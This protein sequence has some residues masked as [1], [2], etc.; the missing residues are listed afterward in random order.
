MSTLLPAVV[1]ECEWGAIN[2]NTGISYRGV[3]SPG[4]ECP[5]M[6]PVG[7]TPLDR[8]RVC[9]CP[10]A[11]QEAIQSRVIIVGGLVASA[12]LSYC[13]AA[14]SAWPDFKIVSVRRSFG[15]RYIVIRGRVSHVDQFL[16]ELSRAFP[17]H[18]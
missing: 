11:P 17:Q 6:I 10:P 7:F 16:T 18:A 3:G 12:I 9:M 14:A 2:L 4:L 1:P 13:D 5:Q 15:K 8:L